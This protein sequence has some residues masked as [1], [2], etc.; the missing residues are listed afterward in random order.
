MERPTDGCIVIDGGGGE[1]S[2]FGFSVEYVRVYVCLFNRMCSP[3]PASLWCYQGLLFTL[4]LRT[5][6]DLRDHLV[7]SHVMEKERED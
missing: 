5:R 2:Y 3:L 1:G 7:S 6:I 4:N